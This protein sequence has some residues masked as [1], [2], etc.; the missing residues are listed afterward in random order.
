MMALNLTAIIQIQEEV[1]NRFT[2]ATKVGP[3]S[4]LSV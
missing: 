3:G 4:S 1:T 2:L